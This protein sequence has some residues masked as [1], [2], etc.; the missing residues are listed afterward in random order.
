[1]EGG[2]I[3]R[4]SVILLGER[5][6]EELVCSYG[7]GHCPLVWTRQGEMWSRG[8]GV[9]SEGISRALHVLPSAG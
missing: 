6:A 2:L 7:P 4:P 3:S 8:R 9:A 5:E 1:M